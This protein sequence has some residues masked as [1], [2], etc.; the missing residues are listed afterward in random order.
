M[1][2]HKSNSFYLLSREGHKICIEIKP[3]LNFIH[4]RIDYVEIT[5]VPIPEIVLKVEL[6]NQTKDNHKSTYLYPD[7]RHQTSSL[8]SYDELC[9]SE[10]MLNNTI[11]IRF[12][13]NSI[14]KPWLACTDYSS[15]IPLSLVRALPAPYP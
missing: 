4:V 14:D 11:Y 8:V 6:L 13:I 7:L 5:E 2:S 1:N 3:I 10:Y 12:T 9:N 15:T